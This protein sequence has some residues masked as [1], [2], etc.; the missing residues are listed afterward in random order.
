MEC[1]RGHSL[2]S[3]TV[4][5]LGIGELRLPGTCFDIYSKSKCAFGICTFA[6]LIILLPDLA[7]YL[8]TY[9][10]CAGLFIGHYSFGSRNDSDT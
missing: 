5:Q 8:T 3:A 2:V 4:F 6:S 9:I 10:L 7:K 1:A